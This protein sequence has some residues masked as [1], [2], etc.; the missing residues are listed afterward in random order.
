MKITLS[1]VGVSGFI[2]QARNIGITVN[3]PFIGESPNNDPVSFDVFIKILSKFVNSKVKLDA[4][5]EQD[6]LS[7]MPTLRVNG[8]KDIGIRN[9]QGAKSLF[10][11]QQGSWTYFLNDALRDGIPSQQVKMLRQNINLL[12]EYGIDNDKFFQIPNTFFKE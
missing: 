1:Q 3:D 7:S 11:N 5:I 6:T 8:I 12:P 9:K 4:F 10:K 2:E